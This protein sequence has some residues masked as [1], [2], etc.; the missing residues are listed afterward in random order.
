[1]AR[2]LSG[3]FVPSIAWLEK[4]QSEKD[5]IRPGHTMRVILAPI[6]VAALIIFRASGVGYFL[7]ILDEWSG[8]KF[9][10]TNAVTVDF[11]DAMKYFGGNPLVY[12]VGTAYAGFIALLKKMNLLI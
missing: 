1:M 10:C 8:Y 11:R 7:E 4:R 6:A 12:V 2:F 5:L 3:E 9:I